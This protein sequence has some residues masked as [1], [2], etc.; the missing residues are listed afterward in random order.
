M[1]VENVQKEDFGRFEFEDG[2]IYEG[3][4]IEKNGVRYRHGNG[5]LFFSSNSN[6]ET[7]FEKYDGEWNLDKMEGFGQ[8]EYISGAIYTGYWK[9]N[10]QNGQGKYEFPDGS[11]YEGEW[12]DHSMHGEGEFTS[13]EGN[14]WKGEFRDG[15]FNSKLQ[16]ELKNQKIIEKKKIVIHRE[17]EL[18]VQN[19]FEIIQLDKKKQ[20]EKLK[21]LFASNFQDEVNLTRLNHF[22]KFQ[23]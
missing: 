11:Y 19:L 2:S 16:N 4:Y 3:N 13:K 20:K 14:T 5:I 6:L 18:F 21:E 23:H 9:N 17:I 7:K 12:I 1:S 10:M 22:L 8:Y 15:N